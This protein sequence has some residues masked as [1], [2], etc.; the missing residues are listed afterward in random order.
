[1]NLTG[2]HFLLTYTCNYEC[3]HCFAWGSP[4]AS[5]TFTLNEIREVYDEAEKIGTVETIY[6]EGGEPFLYY[7]I[8]LKGMELAKQRGFK[9]GIVTNGYFGTALEDATE[10]L[11]PI[12]KIGVD[13]LSVSNDELH[14][15]DPKNSFAT[16]A[17]KAARKL[18][19]P[20]GF[21]EI[22][23]PKSLEPEAK[24]GRGSPLVG[25]DVRFRGRAVEKLIEGLPRKPWD[26]FD[27]CPDEDFQ[28]LGRVHLDPLG[29]VHICQ[30]VTL[31]NFKKTP[32]SKVMEDYDPRSEPIIGP[33]MTGGPAE[34]VRRYNIEH[35]QSYVDACHL[36][37]DARLKL[38]QRFPDKLAPDQMYGIVE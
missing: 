10:W 19:L 18:G 28:K 17:A 26:L 34:L 1:M 31:G 22:E 27:E 23:K 21:L 20:V 8:M 12:K 32:L 25:G 30:G 2:L 5:G 14:Y 13:D 9:V 11:T 36:C 33:L 16:V 15:D 7:P 3:D 38:R 6:F 24:V 37:Y 35:E 29:Y 4:F